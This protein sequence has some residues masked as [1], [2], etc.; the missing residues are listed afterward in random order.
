[1]GGGSAICAD[2]PG[3]ITPIPQ[4]VNAGKLSKNFEKSVVTVEY[5][6]S[7]F[8]HKDM[9]TSKS[10]LLKIA[11]LAI[12][13]AFGTS[14]TTTYDAYGQPRQSVDPGLAIA[15]VA[16]AGLI[17]YAIANNNDNDR[18]Y[19]KSRSNYNRYPRNN[20]YNRNYGHQSRYNYNS[21]RSNE[22]YY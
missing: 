2:T 12:F 4:K 8:R 9:K 5:L 3:I 11:A 17:G 14:C 20:R 10:L 6:F 7:L 21:Y 22:C 19:R 1:V 16:A 15:G 18:N 13:T